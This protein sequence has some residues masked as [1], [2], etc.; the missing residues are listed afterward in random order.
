MDTIQLFILTIKVH[1]HQHPIWF[2]SEIRHSIK[3]LRTLRCR[4]KCCPI[5][6]ISNTIISTEKALQNTITAAKQTFQSDL[7][8]TYASANNS[9]VFKYLKSITKSNNILSVMNLE[10]LTAI[11]DYRIANLFK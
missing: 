9:K 2:N 5:Q 4:Y 3:R 8:N 6:H 11:T 10:S 7:I 1:S